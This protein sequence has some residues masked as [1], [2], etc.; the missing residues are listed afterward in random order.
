[1]DLKGWQPQNRRRHPVTERSEWEFKSGVFSILSLIQETMGLY[2]FI[3]NHDFFPV[4]LERLNI[5]LPWLT[6]RIDV[7]G[8]FFDEII[9]PILKPGRACNASQ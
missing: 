1:M 7:I 9:T 8:W 5:S 6:L 3:I 4:Q 2:M